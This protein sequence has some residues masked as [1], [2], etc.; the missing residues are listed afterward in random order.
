[1]STLITLFITHVMSLMISF[2]FGFTIAIILVL[3]LLLRFDGIKQSSNSLLSSISSKGKLSFRGD[4][5]KR[6]AAHATQMTEVAAAIR[7]NPHSS[8]IRYRLIHY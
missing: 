7:G 6:A 2:A 4:A 8:R 1:M 5:K 3:Y